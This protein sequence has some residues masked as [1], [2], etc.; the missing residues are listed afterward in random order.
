MI[1]VQFPHASFFLQK[2]PY[3]YTH[4]HKMAEEQPE[5]TIPASAEDRKAATA[6]ANLDAIEDASAAHQPVDQAALSK[7]TKAAAQQA[8]A[9]AAQKD[10]NKNVKVDAADVTL[11]VDQLELP[12]PKATELLKNNEGDAV[13]AMRAFVAAS[14]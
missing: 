4:T 2:E 10:A 1:T 13:K 8:P 12:K 11:L 14:S 5:K 7:A 9:A 3:T 6:L